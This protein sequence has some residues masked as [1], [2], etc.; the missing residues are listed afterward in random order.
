MPKAVVMETGTVEVELVMPVIGVTKGIAPEL[1]SAVAPEVIVEAHVDAHLG[2]TSTSRGGMEILAD[3]LVDTAV[4]A[5][6]LESM[7][8]AE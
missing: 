1:G 4:V 3:D 7:H 2:V 8:R 5:R 6:N